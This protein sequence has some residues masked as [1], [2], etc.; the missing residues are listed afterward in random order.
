MF[1]D[2]VARWSRDWS[3][4]LEGKL[5]I[6]CRFLY[7]FRKMWNWQMVKNLELCWVQD[8]FGRR[9]AYHGLKEQGL[10]NLGMECPWL[11]PQNISQLFGR[12]EG[13]NWLIW[14]ITLN[15]TGSFATPQ[16][17]GIETAWRPIRYILICRAIGNRWFIRH[18]TTSETT[19]HILMNKKDWSRMPKRKRSNGT[20][21]GKQQPW[22]DPNC[23]VFGLI[24]VIF[25]CV[26]IF[27]FCFLFLEAENYQFLIGGLSP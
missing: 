3:T 12:Q 22:I 17:Q 18:R 5:R 10:L 19:I 7:K 25:Y 4:K 26:L 20:I 9:T 21:L 23:Y 13:W 1:I 15:S 27:W 6:R 14:V 11:D 2:D 24:F 8:A 16:Y